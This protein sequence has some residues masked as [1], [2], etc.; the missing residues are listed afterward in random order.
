MIEFDEQI[1]ATEDG[2]DASHQED[3]QEGESENPQSNHGISSERRRTVLHGG[4]ILTVSNKFYFTACF[5][6]NYYHVFVC[7]QF[8]FCFVSLQYTFFSFL[9]TF[10]NC[11]LTHSPP[12]I[13]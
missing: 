7:F 4:K 13:V 11:S 8:L 10:W 2:P 5:K 9:Y 6:L 1:N 12:I 3:T